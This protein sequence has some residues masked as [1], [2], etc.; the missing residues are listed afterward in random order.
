M[1]LANLCEQMV[2]I[3]IK[4][5]KLSKFNGELCENL[6][7]EVRYITSSKFDDITSLYNKVNDAMDNKNWLK[8]AVTHKAK[9]EIRKYLNKE[10]EE[11]VNAGKELWEKKVKKLK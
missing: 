5:V 2:S 8:F 1:S 7:V 9:N 3:L 10:E 4:K 11:I 6:Y